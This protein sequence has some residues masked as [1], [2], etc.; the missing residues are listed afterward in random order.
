M[1][2][3]EST[4]RSRN[5]VFSKC[6]PVKLNIFRGFFRRSRPRRAD[7]ISG[8]YVFRTPRR[9]HICS[10]WSYLFNVYVCHTTRRRTYVYDNLASYR[11]T[12]RSA[13]SRCRRCPG[14]SAAGPPGILS[15]TFARRTCITVRSRMHSI[16][17]IRKT[18]PK[19]AHLFTTPLFPPPKKTLRWIRRLVFFFDNDLR[20]SVLGNRSAE[21]YFASKSQWFTIFTVQHHRFPCVLTRG[22]VFRGI[23]S[24]A[25]LPDS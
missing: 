17:S 11:R 16:A 8:R 10:I 3:I 19:I 22:F 7:A 5:T 21:S 25:A 13:C 9:S 2:S 24:R 15:G 6:I 20:A 23:I 18:V 14:G 4:K 12:S 1:R